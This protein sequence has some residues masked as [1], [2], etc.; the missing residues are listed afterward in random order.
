MYIT[1]KTKAEA[2]NHKN[3]I[4]NSRENCLIVIFE[5][6]LIKGASEKFDIN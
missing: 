4:F 5:G 3:Y 6:I 2:R 1:H